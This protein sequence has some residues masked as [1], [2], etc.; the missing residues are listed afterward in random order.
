LQCRATA[1]LSNQTTQDV[2]SQ[3]Q[4]STSDAAIATISAGGLVALL[5]PGSFQVRASHQTVSASRDQVSTFTPPRFYAADGVVR[6]ASGRPIS[7]A[8][9]VA[10]DSG[11][12]RVTRTTDGGG[13]FHMAP[14][15]SGA[16]SFS[17]A[18][19]GFDA[20]SRTVTLNADTRLADIVLIA[21]ASPP[22]SSSMTCSNVPTSAPCGRPTAQCSNGVW[23]CSQTSSGTCSSNG[24]IR[25]RVCPGPLC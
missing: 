12:T 4:W 13:Y 10:Q 19:I 21:V 18:A 15:R 22:P 14:L 11:G 1:T 6:D 2:T 20:A 16:V 17:I 24:G 23:S 25:C 5:G 9:V 8:S 7:S 3:S